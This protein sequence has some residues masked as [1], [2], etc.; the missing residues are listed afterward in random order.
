MLAALSVAMPLAAWG[1]SAEYAMS[2][3]SNAFLKCFA[4]FPY[5]ELPILDGR[6]ALLE[7]L[8]KDRAL[9]FAE[10]LEPL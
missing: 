6:P 1:V 4:A 10:V 7:L 5:Q 3:C 8:R 2:Y 9:V